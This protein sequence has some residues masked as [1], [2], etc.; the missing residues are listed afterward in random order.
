MVTTRSSSKG[1][2]STSIADNGVSP[3]RELLD[4]EQ[5]AA[6]PELSSNALRRSAS[7]ATKQS[8][9]EAQDTPSTKES[10]PNS[11]RKRRATSQKI[12]NDGRDGDRDIDDGTMKTST[13]PPSHLQ[14]DESIYETPATRVQ[15]SAYATPA[16][17][18]VK[19]LP[20][21]NI[22]PASHVPKSR[23]RKSPE[24][25]EEGMGVMP[26]DEQD[27]STATAQ[28]QTRS[29]RIRFNSEEPASLPM[30]TANVVEPSNSSINAQ[31]ESESDDDDAPEAITNVDAS[32][33]AKAADLEASKAAAAQRAAAR[34]KRKQRDT[35]LK[36]QA[37]DADTR[38][39]KRRR[40]EAVAER[41]QD[42][43][44]S[45]VE[46]ITRVEDPEEGLTTRLRFSKVPALLPQ[47]L[48]DA[49]PEVRPLSPPPALEPTP[50][51]NKPNKIALLSPKH[52]KDVKRGPVSVHVLKDVNPLLPPKAD[53]KL[54]TV[55]ATREAWMMGRAGKSGKMKDVVGS[56]RMERRAIVTG[57]G[58]GFFRR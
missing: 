21:D 40:R 45:D 42:E 29:T 23:K 18:L 17:H 34:S 54:G 6:D 15:S 25:G 14:D 38:G 12:A 20:T 16:T 7:K 55:R 51:S 46:E 52:P 39:R 36:A 22:T 58:G 56:G 48:L 10:K 8:L 32:Q 49:A 27:A 3:S 44:E 1:R 5:A 37:E 57:G 19:T 11:S 35:V 31:I 50:G 43:E 13:E 26:P 9:E 4:E 47:E 41:I 28:P 24:D 2:I 30:Q 33:S 53:K